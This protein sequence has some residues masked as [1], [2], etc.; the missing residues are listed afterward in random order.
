MTCGLCGSGITA[1]EKFKKQKNGN[2]HRHV[3]YGCTKVR[4]RNCKCGY[5]NEIDLIKQFENLIDR[6]DV[7]EIGIKEKIKEKVK[8]IKKFN[9]M[10][11]GNNEYTLIKNIDIKNYTKYILEYGKDIEKRELLTCLKSKIIM[12]GKQIYLDTKQHL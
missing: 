4:D 1:D 5:I 2:I 9:Q 11:L 3:Y 10:I 8:E 6:I 7:D 12:K